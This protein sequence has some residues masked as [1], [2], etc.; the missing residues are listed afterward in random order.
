MT[1]GQDNQPE[2]A[3]LQELIAER[4]D[5]LRRRYGAHALGIGR[6]KLGGQKTGQLALRV[7]VDQEG[8]RRMEDAEPVPATVA[9]TPSGMNHPVHL[10]TEVVQ[11]PPAR[12]EEG[13]AEQV[14]DLSAT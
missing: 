10:A 14:V 2:Y 5:E 9:F 12:L 6:K 7:Y 1:A 13:G 8:A 11:S 4:G 3:W